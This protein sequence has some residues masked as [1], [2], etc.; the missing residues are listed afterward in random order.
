MPGPLARIN[1]VPSSPFTSP[2][3]E[4]C[5]E[6]NDT[7]PALVEATVT[8]SR[9]TGKVCSI[10]VDALVNGIWNPTCTGVTP[11][12]NGPV[13]VILDPATVAC[14][15]DPSR[16]DAP[17]AAFGRSTISGPPISTRL[18]ALFTIS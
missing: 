5:G 14:G 2:T 13:A 15:E 4:N 9:G 17:A 7:C 16:G 1:G 12:A 8:C 10:V 18:R 3:D 11:D 6:A